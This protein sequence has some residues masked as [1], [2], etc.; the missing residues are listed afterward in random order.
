VWPICE[1]NAS[2]FTARV[3]SA[4]RLGEIVESWMAM[5]DKMSPFHSRKRGLRPTRS[6]ARVLRAGVAMLLSPGSRR[7]PPTVKTVAK[8]VTGDLKH[9]GCQL[10]RRNG[11][12]LTLGAG[13]HALL[14]FLTQ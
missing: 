5:R 6:S 2:L 4:D 12:I 10:A 1:G 13:N 14:C 11:E 8:S 9:L 3:A 7:I